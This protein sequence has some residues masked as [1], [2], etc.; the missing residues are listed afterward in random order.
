[1]EVYDRRSNTLRVAGQEIVPYD[2]RLCLETLPELVNI[3][4]ALIRSETKMD[5]LRLLIQKP[6][7]GNVKQLG[8]RINGLMREKFGFDCRADWAEELPQRWKGVTVIEEKD[9]RATHG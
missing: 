7:T 1:M 3:P 8:T 5:S 6:P 4:F 2:V 9:W